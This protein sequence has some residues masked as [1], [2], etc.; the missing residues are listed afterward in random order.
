[1]FS[2]QRYTPWLLSL[3]ALASCDYTSKQ[4]GSWDRPRASLIRD[5]VYLEG[6]K[7]QTG[8]WK[9]GAWGVTTV[10]IT[11]GALFNLSL[12]EAFGVYEDSAPAVFQSIPEAAVNNYYLDGYMFASYD[13]F[14]AW[15]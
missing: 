4:I 2:T 8:G 15:G 9:D 7:I 5:Y 6:G 14:Y 10:T 12:H 13:E 3:V 11:Q 1:M